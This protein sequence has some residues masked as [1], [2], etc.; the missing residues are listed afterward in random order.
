ML[1]RFYPPTK[2]HLFLSD[3]ETESDDELNNYV[4]DQHSNK[5]T[6]SNNR[7]RSIKK[8]CKRSNSKKVNGESSQDK[9]AFKEEQEFEVMKDAKKYQ[10][11]MK[12]FPIPE[13]VPVPI[14]ISPIPSFITWQRLGESMKQKYEQPLHYLTQILLKQWDES[15]GN[16]EVMMRKPIGNVIDPIKAE[17]SV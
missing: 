6:R 14:R 9:D 7:R 3:S 17:A 1:K 11:K 10:Q 8:E 4:K 5:N 13:P 16:N 12:K 2:D 15:R